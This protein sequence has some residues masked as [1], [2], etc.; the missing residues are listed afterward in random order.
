MDNHHNTQLISSLY[1][2][3]NFQQKQLKSLKNT[4]SDQY[5]RNE[6]LSKTKNSTI[7]KLQS[8]LTKEKE[9]NQETLIKLSILKRKIRSLEELNEIHK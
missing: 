7:K 9:I 1:D 2:I 4:L 6:Q 5:T 8:Q 3:I